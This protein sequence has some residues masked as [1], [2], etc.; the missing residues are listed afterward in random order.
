MSEPVPDDLRCTRCG[1]LPEPLLCLGHKP[2]GTPVT[3]TPAA[4]LALEAEFALA[5]DARRRAAGTLLTDAQTA[6]LL[7][8]MIDDPEPGT[9]EH[10]R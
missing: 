3:D 7:R 8:A 10:E 6:A 1:V 2:D 4:L 5:E 9:G